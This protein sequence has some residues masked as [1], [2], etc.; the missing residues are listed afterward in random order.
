MVFP[1]K[2]WDEKGRKHGSW[3]TYWDDQEKHLMMSSCYNHG[4]EVGISRTFHEN[5][6]RISVFK[7][8][9][10]Y[11]KVKIYDTAGF[12]DAKG[13]AILGYDA[14]STLNYFWIG[15]WKFFDSK[16]RLIRYGYYQKGDE[17][18]RFIPA[19]KK[20]WLRLFLKGDSLP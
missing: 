10:H 11:V 17:L 15:K 5:G 9:K 4:K 1:N 13:K 16:H 8:H 19:K 14:D 6:E 12:V 7:F 18:S 3:K 20:R 2:K